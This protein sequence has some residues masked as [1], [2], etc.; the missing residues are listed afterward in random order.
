MSLE[1]SGVQ[2]KEAPKCKLKLDKF[3][4]C[5]KVKDNCSDKKLT[6]T[7]NERKTL[8]ECSKILND[9]LLSGIED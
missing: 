6:G 9:G 5:Q 1:S 7:E 4:L 2:L 8:V 3:V